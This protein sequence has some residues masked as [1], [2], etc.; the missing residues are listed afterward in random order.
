VV[1]ER[2]L[3]SSGEK[4]RGSVSPVSVQFAN[5]VIT[6]LAALAQCLPFALRLNRIRPPLRLLAAILLRSMG[7]AGFEPATSRV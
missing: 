6:M 2:P 7:A 5:N 4:P 3:L 1:P